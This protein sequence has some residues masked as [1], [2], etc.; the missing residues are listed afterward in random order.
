LLPKSRYPNEESL[1][2]VRLLTGWTDPRRA[3]RICPTTWPTQP[4]EGD[5]V[6]MF[7]PYLMVGFMF[8]PSSFLKLVL[9]TYGLQLTHLMPNSMFA[10]SVFI[11][12][13]E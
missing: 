10:L 4:L 5:E 6:V 3:V 11:Y 2:G 12:L 1:K 8:P 13:C 9:E 7:M